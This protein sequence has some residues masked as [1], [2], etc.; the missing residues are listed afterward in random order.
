M[1]A[2][3]VNDINQT[4]SLKQPSLSLF[5][6]SIIEQSVWPFLQL[7]LSLNGK[8]LRT[9]AGLAEDNGLSKPAVTEMLVHILKDRIKKPDLLYINYSGSP[10]VA[11]E[12]LVLSQTTVT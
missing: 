1:Q 6:K 7:Y 2:G 10:S 12:E 8:S 11:D 3:P 4:V 5:D 9:L